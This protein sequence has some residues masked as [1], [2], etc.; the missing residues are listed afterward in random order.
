MRLPCMEPCI[1]VSRSNRSVLST[2]SIPG[3]PLTG[4]E[5][6]LTAGYVF[7][8]VRSASLNLVEH[9]VC[10]LEPALARHGGPHVLAGPSYK[11]PDQMTRICRPCHGT[12][13][14]LAFSK[15]ATLPATGRQ[16][17]ANRGRRARAVGS[18]DQPAGSATRA[19]IDVV[20]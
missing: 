8:D 11:A 19:G 16:G 18:D 2:Q 4:L 20:L 3:P 17:G 15:G 10:N 12:A 5:S 6:M 1:E 14:V 9:P 7:G 13:Y